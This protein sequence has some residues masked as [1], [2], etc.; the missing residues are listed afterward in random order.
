MLSVNLLERTLDAG[1]YDR[2][3]RELSD[4]GLSLPLA[5]QVALASNP[6]AVQGLALRRLVELTYGPTTL[7]KQLQAELRNA[8]GAD[9]GFAAASAEGGSQEQMCD[10]LCT[11]AALSGLARVM[12]DHPAAAETAALAEPLGRGFARLGRLQDCDGLFTAPA[13]RSLAD[14]ALTTAFVV[15]LLGAVPEF[16][17]SVRL[18]E[19]RDWFD[20]HEDRLDRQVRGLWELAQVNLLDLPA[21]HRLAPAA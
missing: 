4:N 11:A 8:Q 7:S 18:Y 17:S 15:Q 19:L 14:R 10:A 6:A 13:D 1:D 9:G 16:R 3:L 20:R 5:I 2:L 12:I 21:E